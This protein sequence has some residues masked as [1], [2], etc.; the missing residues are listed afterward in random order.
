M[1]D[2]KT[3]LEEKKKRLLFVLV[4]GT[5]APKSAWTQRGSPLREK[6]KNQFAPEILKEEIEFYVPSWGGKNDESARDKGALD[7]AKDV[8]NMLQASDA[9]TDDVKVFFVSH[10]HGTDV[11]I[12]AI[13][14]IG[15]DFHIS[16]LVGFNS[17]NIITLKRDFIANFS[18]NFGLLKTAF[19]I[20]TAF[21]VVLFSMYVFAETRGTRLGDIEYNL[22]ANTQNIIIFLIVFIGSSYFLNIKLLNEMREEEGNLTVKNEDAFRELEAKNK[23]QF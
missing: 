13:E 1:T 4:H 9:F 23:T 14:F 22:L 7:I 10:S 2:R 5:W 12:K 8:K 16:G 6:L 11:S 21:F 15:E 3:I 17:P 20:L 19:Y 18:T